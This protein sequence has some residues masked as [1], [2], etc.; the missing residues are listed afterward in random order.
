MDFPF[1][2]RS[3][4]CSAVRQMLFAM[5][6]PFEA[7]STLQ[8]FFSLPGFVEVLALSELTTAESDATNK[9]AANRKCI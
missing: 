3:S 5:R 9:A 2:L 6:E 8:I 1:L 4:H 7:G